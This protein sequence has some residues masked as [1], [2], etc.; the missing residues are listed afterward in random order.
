[1]V[2][3]INY[4]LKEFIN[5]L[6]GSYTSREALFSERKIKIP[7]SNKFLSRGRIIS[8]LQYGKNI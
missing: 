8:A 6:L 2:S 4:N 5:I 7:L 1:M 3:T